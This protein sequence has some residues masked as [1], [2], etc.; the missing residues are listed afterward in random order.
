MKVTIVDSTPP[1]KDLV[2]AGNSFKRS[3]VVEEISPNTKYLYIHYSRT[4]ATS[5]VFNKK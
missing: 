2:V 3:G 5:I 1:Q 4:L